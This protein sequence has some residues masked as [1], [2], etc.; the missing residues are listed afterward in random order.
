MFSGSGIILAVLG[1]AIVA[2]HDIAINIA[3]LFFMIP[4]SIGLA[5]ATRVGNL[6]GEEN[7]QT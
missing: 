5:A 7:I 1:D 4:L 3:S 2:S 6:I